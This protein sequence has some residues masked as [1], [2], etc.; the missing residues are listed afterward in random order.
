[1]T[2]LLVISEP[3]PFGTEGDNVA[4]PVPQPYLGQGIA[5]RFCHHLPFHLL[6]LLIDRLGSLSDLE[7]WLQHLAT[8]PFPPGSLIHRRL[9]APTLRTLVPWAR[10]EP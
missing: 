2:L 4:K 8:K 7:Q 9:P 10:A 3:L 1:M 6:L 5:T